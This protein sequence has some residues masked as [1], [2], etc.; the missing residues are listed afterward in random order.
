MGFDTKIFGIEPTE[1]LICGICLDVYENCY[2]TSCNHKYCLECLKLIL[3]NN[4]CAFCRSNIT[5]KNCKKENHVDMKIERLPIFC[6]SCKSNYS[7]FTFKFHKCS[8]YN[9]ILNDD[10]LI[11]SIFR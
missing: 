1:E 4:E 5:M 11:F 2:I 8:I 9:P 10:T 3:K 7:I 6:K